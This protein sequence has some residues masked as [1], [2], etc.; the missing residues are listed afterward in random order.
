MHFGHTDFRRVTASDILWLLDIFLEAGCEKERYERKQVD[1]ERKSPPDLGHVT[2]SDH[3]NHQNSIE[4]C[5][6]VSVLFRTL[7]SS[8]KVGNESR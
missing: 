5:R 4:H 6:S 2:G 8:E 3:G 7:R 1:Q